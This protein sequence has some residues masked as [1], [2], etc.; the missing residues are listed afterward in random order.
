M[1]E[2]NEPP[3]LAALVQGL[4]CITSQR[5]CD[6]SA[7]GTGELVEDNIAI[8]VISKA[9]GWGGSGFMKV[10]DIYRGILEK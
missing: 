8:T 3:P 7:K 10:C 1:T 4:I 2:A 5:G 6:H 9:R